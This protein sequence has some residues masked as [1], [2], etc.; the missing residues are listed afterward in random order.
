MIIDKKIASLTVIE[1]AVFEQL[2]SLSYYFVQVF[3]STSAYQ[4]T[5]FL[6]IN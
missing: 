1:V 5:L 3:L 6:F 2:E 4:Q